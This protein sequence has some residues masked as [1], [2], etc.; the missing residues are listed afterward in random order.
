MMNE[1][2]A[3]FSCQGMSIK[4]NGSDESLLVYTKGGDAKIGVL[5]C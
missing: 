2:M 5:E 3:Y 4:K 1:W